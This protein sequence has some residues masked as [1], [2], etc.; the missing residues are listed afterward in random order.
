MHL[1]PVTRTHAHAYTRTHRFDRPA[2]RVP[3]LETMHGSS[4]QLRLSSGALLVRMSKS[5]SS[6]PAASEQDTTSGTTAPE[7]EAGPG[8]SQGVDDEEA[9]ASAPTF[10]SVAQVAMDPAELY[11]ILAE[12]VPE[13][14]NFARAVLAGDVSRV[15]ELLSAASKE[16]EAAYLK[17]PVLVQSIR[18][19]R[20]LQYPE[21]AVPPLVAAALIKREDIADVLLDRLLEEL[22]LDWDSSDRN[23]QARCANP[24]KPRGPDIWVLAC[25]GAVSQRAADALLRLLASN[26]RLKESGCPEQHLLSQGTRKSFGYMEQGLEMKNCTPLQVAVLVGGD[27]F[28]RRLAQAGCKHTLA[29]AVQVGDT[30]WLDQHV[31]MWKGEV[32]ALQTQFVFVEFLNHCY[33]LFSVG[34]ASK[35]S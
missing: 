31:E 9:E 11:R 6:S 34:L 21:V 30:E 24:A 1:H 10:P 32:L 27:A 14:L 23:Q 16:E 35:Q 4:T 25:A 13:E 20:N 29:T 19:C 28:A 26:P 5:T 15:K 8:P 17:T 18:L 22:L 3:H 7:A 2:D 33:H 12:F